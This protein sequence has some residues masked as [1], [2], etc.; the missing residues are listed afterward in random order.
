[1]KSGLPVATDKA[2]LFAYVDPQLKAK[3]ERLADIRLRSVS[4]LVESVMA[5]EVAR[6]EQEGLL[7][8]PSED[9]K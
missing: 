2:K 8:A 7:P 6:A 1:M 9:S 4:N 5:E 3:I